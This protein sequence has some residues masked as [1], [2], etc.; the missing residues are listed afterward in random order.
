MPPSKQKG[1]KTDQVSKFRR[2]QE[3][4]LIAARN[5]L[6]SE[7]TDYVLERLPQPDDSGLRAL[8]S[9]GILNAAHSLVRRDG[10]YPM[11]RVS[12]WRTTTRFLREIGDVGNRLDELHRLDDGWMDG[13]GQAP[14]AALLD[15]LRKQL[16][17][18]D[19]AAFPPP[20]LYPTLEGG[21]Q[22]EWSADGYE[23]SL[24]FPASG[25]VGV[26]HE[27][28]VRTGDES[29]RQVELDDEARW[30]WVSQRLRKIYGGV[31]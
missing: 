18:L 23:V 12:L 1:E 21:V 20:F 6:D 17:G 13:E 2:D 27:I 10:A 8:I 16:S 4:V 7:F 24:E 30:Q 31:T 9:E 22:A 26:W 29:E 11:E 25:E 19:L 15:R 3:E 14:S 5:A 28:D